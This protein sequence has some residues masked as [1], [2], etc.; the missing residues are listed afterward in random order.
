MR[1][2]L[3]QVKPDDVFSRL[4][5]PGVRFVMTHHRYMCQEGTTMPQRCNPTEEV[6]VFKAAPQPTPWQR[7]KNWLSSL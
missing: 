2:Q 6:E 7:L 1:M 4:V 5:L 3:S